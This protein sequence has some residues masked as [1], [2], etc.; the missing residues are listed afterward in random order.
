SSSLPPLMLPVTVALS[1]SFRRSASSTPQARISRSSTRRSSS[2]SWATP[3]DDGGLAT[4]GRRA[5][6]GDDAHARTTRPRPPGDRRHVAGSPHLVR[7]H[8]RGAATLPHRPS[9]VE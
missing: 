3:P 1:C 6:E 9:L 7:S 2:T 4:L 5:R 8:R